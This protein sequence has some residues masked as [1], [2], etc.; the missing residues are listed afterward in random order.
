MSEFLRKN[1]PVI[2]AGVD[3]H[4]RTCPVP[5]RAIL[6]HPSEHAKL[7]V[8]SLWD[9]DV[10]ADQRV[11]LGRFRVDCDGSAWGVEDELLAFIESSSVKERTI[12]APETEQ[13]LAARR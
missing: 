5:A 6:L 1:I 3:S 4:N 2:R 7:G 11:P 13:P 9:L 10:I 12:P 8:L